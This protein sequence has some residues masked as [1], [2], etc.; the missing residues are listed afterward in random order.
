[1]LLISPERAIHHV[2]I[3]SIFKKLGKTLAKLQTV[4]LFRP[5]SLFSAVGD[6]QEARGF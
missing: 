1:M 6:R 2:F 3:V 5:I 4:T